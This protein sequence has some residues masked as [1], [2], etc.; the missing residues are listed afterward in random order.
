M[1]A[2]VC[3]CARE[4]AWREWAQLAN[5]AASRRLPAPFCRDL[6]AINPPPTQTHTHLQA[7]GAETR[8]AVLVCAHARRVRTR[9]TSSARSKTSSRSASSS[10]SNCSTATRHVGRRC[11]HTTAAPRGPAPKCSPRPPVAV[12]PSCHVSPCCSLRRARTPPR[13]H[14]HAHTA[15]QARSRSTWPHF[16]GPPQ[17]RGMGVWWAS[18]GGRVG[19]P[20]RSSLR[21]PCPSR[22]HPRSL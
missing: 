15:T 4:R 22:L 16:I 13:H 8:G 3:V 18:S 11:G 9:L 1:R 14:A 6:P 20:F 19:N 21:C 5:L 2:C 17:R 7:P 10:S 12:P